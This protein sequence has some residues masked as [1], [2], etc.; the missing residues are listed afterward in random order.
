VD[1][2]STFAF[3][4]PSSVSY[5]HAL[6]TFI[7]G[8]SEMYLWGLGR[9]AALGRH[10]IEKWRQGTIP[11]KNRALTTRGNG[12]NAASLTSAI[13][14]AHSQSIRGLVALLALLR[15]PCWGISAFCATCNSAYFARRVTFGT[16]S[17]ARITIRPRTLPHQSLWTPRCDI[18]E[19]HSAEL[20]SSALRV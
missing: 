20:A 2:S 13:T 12:P 17:S 4:P 11:R 6:G 10:E 15:H 16:T 5:V 3:F 8:P 9:R 19:W 1:G 7:S 14:N 18:S